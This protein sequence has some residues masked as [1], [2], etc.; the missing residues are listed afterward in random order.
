[1]AVDEQRRAA[2][3]DAHTYVPLFRRSTGH[4]VGVAAAD[5][6]ALPRVRPQS[7][8]VLEV[9]RTFHVE[10]A[11]YFNGYGE[12]RYCDVVTVTSTG[13]SVITDF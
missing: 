7:S 13:A 10:P 1:M 4:G 5:P 6:K 12:I 3:V 2:N 9:D 11:A 8:D